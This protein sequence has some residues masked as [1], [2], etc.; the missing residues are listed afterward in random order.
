MT[1]AL[2][3]RTLHT[4]IAEDRS[5]KQPPKIPKLRNSKGI[6]LGPPPSLGALYSCSINCFVAHH[7]LVY[8]FILQRG[9]SDQNLQALKTENPA[10]VLWREGYNSLHFFY[11]RRLA[12]SQVGQKI[13]FGVWGERLWKKAWNKIRNRKPINWERQCV[14][15]FQKWDWGHLSLVLLAFNLTSLPKFCLKMKV[16][17]SQWGL[18]IETLQKLS[19]TAIVRWKIFDFRSRL[20]MLF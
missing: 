20:W 2:I 15:Y 11:V 19:F 12:L 9:Q 18:S 16:Q 8:L 4:L 5:A 17:T 10:I 6:T 1:R 7:C 3:G 14:L 13:Q